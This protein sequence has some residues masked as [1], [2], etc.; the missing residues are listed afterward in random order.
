M[1]A[2]ERAFNLFR[3]KV[4]DRELTD[5]DVKRILRESTDSAERQAAW[6][7]GKKVAPSS[8]TI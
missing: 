1:N 2:M 5:N 3:P 7:A 6:E 4:G 8:P